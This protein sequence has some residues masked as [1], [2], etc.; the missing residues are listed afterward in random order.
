MLELELG[1]LR[2]KIERGEREAKEREVMA[3]H[4]KEENLKRKEGKGAWYLK[5][6]PFFTSFQLRTILTIRRPEGITAQ[7]S[8]RASQRTRWSEGCQEGYRE[9]EEE[10]RKQGEKVSTFREGSR[11][12][13]GS[14]WW[15]V[16]WCRGGTQE[17]SRRLICILTSVL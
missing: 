2:T 15:R 10:D 14:C 7:S 8:V 12:T 3:G 16:R 4:K 6:S 13:R 1:R 17:A 5:K 11:W 9:E